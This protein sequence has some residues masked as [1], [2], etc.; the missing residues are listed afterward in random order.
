V[1]KDLMVQE[2][3]VRTTLDL[4]RDLV[5]RSNRMVDQGKVKSRNVLIATALEGYLDS[6]EKLEIDEAFAAMQEDQAYCSLVLDLAADFA[7]SDQEA[8]DTVEE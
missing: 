8:L 3:L 4:P 5:E 7:G 2:R 1:G 6:L